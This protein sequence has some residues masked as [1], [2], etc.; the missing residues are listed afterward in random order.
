MKDLIE[1]INRAKESSSLVI[2]EDK[3]DKAALKELGFNNIF[4][5]SGKPLYSKLDKI[6]EIINKKRECIILT[7]FDK[8]GKQFY[9]LIKKNLVRKGIKVNDRLRIALIKEKISHVEG[10][11]TFIQHLMTKHDSRQHRKRKREFL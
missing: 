4:I 7:D 6:S 3:K 10:L 2:V 9:Y 1:E 8:K 5:L 11:A